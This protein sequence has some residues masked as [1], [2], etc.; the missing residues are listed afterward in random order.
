MNKR[1]ELNSRRR[2][3][4]VDIENTVGNGVLGTE[5]VA[6]VKSSMEAFYSIGEQDFVVI[7]VSHS[8]NVFPSHVWESARIVLKKGHNGADAALKNVLKSERIVD[9]FSEVVIVSGDG[10]F[11]E[12]AGSL[13][14]LGVAVTI[15]AEA[16]RVAKRLLRSASLANLTFKQNVV[17][18]LKIVA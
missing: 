7:G 1:M 6:R 17:I 13:R 5:D 11:A 9:R 14:S 16:I 2:L 3:F 4:I 8:N 10:A 12:E 18:K 15:H